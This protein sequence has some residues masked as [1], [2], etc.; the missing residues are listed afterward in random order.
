MITI[1]S[2]LT[3][4][5]NGVIGSDLTNQIIMLYR[6]DPQLGME[7]ALAALVYVATGGEEIITDKKILQIVLEGSRSFVEK[8][9]SRFLEKQGALESKEIKEK[10]LDEIAHLLRQGMSQAA[11]ARELKIAKSTMSDRCKIIKTKYP[12]LLDAASGQ[13]PFLNPDD[14]DESYETE[15]IQSISPIS[16]VRESGFSRMSGPESSISGRTNVKMSGTFEDETPI[17][18]YSSSENP[19]IRSVRPNKNKNKN[20]NNNNNNNTF[21]QPDHAVRADITKN[22]RINYKNDDDKKI[23]MNPNPNDMIKNPDTSSE[24]YDQ[25]IRINPD[26]S[27]VNQNSGQMIKNDMTENPDKSG[28]KVIPQLTIEAANNLLGDL[29]V[30]KDYKIEKGILHILKDDK[31]YRLPQV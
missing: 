29:M 10:R 22:E 11:A 19:E 5:R 20:K 24:V 9:A 1:P 14:S 17:L 30:G 8:N 6:D 31:Y 3:N 18:S 23:R 28:Q 25:K 26:E 13:F 21:F 4:I 16:F 15:Q 7:L 2:E 12:H 27:R